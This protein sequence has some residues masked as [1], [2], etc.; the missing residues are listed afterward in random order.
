MVFHLLRGDA[1]Q[2]LASPLGRLGD[3]T[4]ASGLFIYYLFHL[5]QGSEQ[6]GIGKN[7]EWDCGMII[8]EV[9]M[10]A[11]HCRSPESR[12]RLRQS[13]QREGSKQ[14][15]FD[16]FT[17]ALGSFQIFRQSASWIKFF[18]FLFISFLFFF[19]SQSCHA[20]SSLR[21]WRR[22]RNWPGN[23]HICAAR[24]PQAAPR[25]KPVSLLST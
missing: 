5:L 13:A 19:F 10:T 15:M 25:P 24:F 8:A 3:G 1:L 14:Q 21:P 12:E 23:R 20:K 7:G 2:P 17:C 22:H 9:H 18:L 6:I 4:V 16:A 11:R